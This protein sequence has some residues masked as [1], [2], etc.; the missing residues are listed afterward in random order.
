MRPCDA[1][2]RTVHYS[3]TSRRQ[4]WIVWRPDQAATHQGAPPCLPRRL[5][6]ALHRAVLAIPGFVLLT[7]FV[8]GA[9]M[10]LNA[11]TASRATAAGSR[12]ANLHLT[13]LATKPGTDIGPASSTTNGTLPAHA[14][15]TVTIVNQDLGDTPNVASR[16]G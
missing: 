11:A 1:R 8:L 7:A 5:P 12:T 9:V 6:T 10:V 15:V 3:V 14:K 16:S 13:L 2:V 4:R